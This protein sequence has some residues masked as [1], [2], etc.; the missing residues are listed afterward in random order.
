MMRI[1]LT[2]VNT[3]SNVGSA[4]VLEN[5]VQNLREVFPQVEMTLSTV[6]EETIAEFMKLPTVPELFPRPPRLGTLPRKV[7][8]LIPNAI[9]MGVNSLFLIL[10]RYLKLPYLYQLFTFSPG[11]RRYVKALAH[12]DLVIS[13]GSERINDNFH[14]QLYFALYGYWFAKML[15]KPMILYAQTIGPLRFWQSR[16]L[17]R[18]VLNKCDVITVRDKRSLEVLEEISVTRPKIE[19]V[20]DPAIQQK[21]VPEETALRLLAQEGVDLAAKPRLGISVLRWNYSNAPSGKKPEEYYAEY[22]ATVSRLADHFLE[23]YGGSVIFVSTNH[24]VHGNRDDDKEVARDVLARMQHKSRAFVLE[25]LY[26]PDELK[27]II[28]EMDLFIASRMHSCI[29]S[30]AMHVPTLA[31]SYQFKL[32]AFMALL[33]MERFAKDFAKLSFEELRDDLDL[34]WSEREQVRADLKKAID[35]LLPEARRSAG[36]VRQFVQGWPEAPVQ[37]QTAAL[38]EQ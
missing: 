36:I 30:T 37:Q 9:W 13:I 15:G 3:I 38:Q 19:L 29:F 1:L 17:T 11:R 24:A 22:V 7:R 5:V 25:K 12:A 8:W 20:A 18:W 16:W 2:E 31:L 23:R 4:S 14:Q 27:G 21:P 26:R 6:N 35:R 10:H 32:R 33:G 34:L 28:G